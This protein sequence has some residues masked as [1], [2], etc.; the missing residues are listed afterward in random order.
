MISDALHTSELPDKGALIKV[1]Q[2]E[3]D[4]RKNVNIQAASNISPRK[5][6][7]TLG[8][9]TELP[10]QQDQKKPTD[11]GGRPPLLQRSRHGAS[12]SSST[13]SLNGDTLPAIAGQ[14]KAFG[15]KAERGDRKTHV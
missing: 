13:S 10:Q 4:K 2:C 11:H 1:V 15:E 6:A 8:V 14:I 3:A 7:S 9:I 5:R 12:F